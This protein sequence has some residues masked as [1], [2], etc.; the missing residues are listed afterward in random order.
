MSS[1]SQQNYWNV[2]GRKNNT[3]KFF[4]VRKKKSNIKHTRKQNPTVITGGDNMYSD[5]Y[6]NLIEMFC[7]DNDILVYFILAPQPPMVV[8]STALV[9]PSTT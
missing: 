5:N 6:N 2:R 1:R 7:N 8:K 4:V 9:P 3:A